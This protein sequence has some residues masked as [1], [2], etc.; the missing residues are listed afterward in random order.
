MLITIIA[1]D[2]PNS[3]ELR[4]A[5]REA[6]L[7]YAGQ[8]GRVKIGGPFLDEDGG[9][10]GSLI[11]LDVPDMDAA[12]EWAA[13]DPYAKAGLFETVTIDYWKQTVG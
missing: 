4:Q 1:R 5:T 8:T 3:L 6:H 10:I 7:A 2:K 11:V 9:M 13:N 12:K